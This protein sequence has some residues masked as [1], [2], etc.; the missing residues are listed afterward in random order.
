[1]RSSPTANGRNAVA[2][3][4]STP[5]SG[6]SSPDRKETEMSTS[7]ARTRTP[8]TSRRRSCPAPREGMVVGTRRTV[9]PSAADRALRCRDMA[10]QC[11]QLSSG[12][13]SPGAA[14]HGRATKSGLRAQKTVTSGGPGAARAVNDL[15]LL[16]A[17]PRPHSDARQGA[18]GE[19]HRDLRL[20][21]D[22]L[23]EPLQ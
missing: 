3:A 6:P 14:R 22:A 16:E 9:R 21:P 23:V 5:L 11:S 18:L 2:P 20:V 15:E 7:D 10:S 8:T 4:D 19:V 1:M 17:P 12:I 13:S